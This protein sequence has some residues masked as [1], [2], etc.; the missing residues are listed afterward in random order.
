LWSVI[1][2]R[3]SIPSSKSSRNTLDEELEAIIKALLNTPPLPMAEI[4]RKREP[5]PKRRKRAAKKRR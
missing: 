4:P 3:T 1:R 5:R 2:K